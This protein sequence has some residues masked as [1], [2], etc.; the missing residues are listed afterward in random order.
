MPPDQDAEQQ[1]PDQP[2]ADSPT[3]VSTPDAPVA[4]ADPPD[5]QEVVQDQTVTE[6]HV[7]ERAASDNEDVVDDENED[8]DSEE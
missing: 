5:G 2:L 3:Q 4:P 7:E 6:T 1:E 8:G